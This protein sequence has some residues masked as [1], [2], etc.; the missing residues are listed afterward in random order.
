MLLRFLWEFLI[1]FVEV[2]VSSDWVDSLIYIFDFFLYVLF[3]EL[4]RE[5]V[6]WQ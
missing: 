2:S 6:G 4:M 3:S 1:F 5:K